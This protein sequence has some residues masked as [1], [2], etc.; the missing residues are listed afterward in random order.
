M[1]IQ[2]ANTEN[3]Y[4]RIN[5]FF[6]KIWKEEFNLDRFDKIDEYK[7]SEVYFIENNNEI[8][9]AINIY[10]NEDWESQIWRFATINSK[11]WSWI[12]TELI[13]YS[14]KEIISKWEK[15]IILYAEINRVNYYKT[16][17]FKEIWKEIEI[18]NTK[19]IKMKLKI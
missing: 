10:K 17:W 6:W 1:N 7:K 14:L 5:D 18:W 4:I 8:I 9:S 19:A 2:K 3:D 11:R 15:N 16:I 13:K 12:W